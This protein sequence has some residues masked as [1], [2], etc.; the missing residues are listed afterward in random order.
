MLWGYKMLLFRYF[1]PLSRASLLL[2]IHLGWKQPLHY[3]WLLSRKARLCAEHQFFFKN[4]RGHYEPPNFLPSRKGKAG[5]LSKQVTIQA[6]NVRQHYAHMLAL[7]WAEQPLCSHCI[8][9]GASMGH[10]K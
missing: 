5:S 9:N 7:S 4:D 10:N 3:A 1:A 2:P 8:E 6:H